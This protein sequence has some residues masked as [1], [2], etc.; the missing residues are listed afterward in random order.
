MTRFKFR[1]KEDPSGKGGQEG[2]LCEWHREIQCDVN[3]GA[4]RKIL[5]ES[6]GTHF[7]K[8]GHLVPVVLWS[9]FLPGLCGFPLGSH[10][11]S[12]HMRL[13][14]LKV[15]VNVYVAMIQ[16]PIH[17][18]VLSTVLIKIVFSCYT[19][20]QSLTPIWQCTSPNQ[21]KGKFNKSEDHTCNSC[22]DWSLYPSLWVINRLQ[23]PLLFLMWLRLL[24]RLEGTNPNPNYISVVDQSN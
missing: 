3:M 18:V 10:S 8:W 16:E 23:T 7:G 11:K 17:C 12:M 22:I 15:W 24:G 19:L 4:A 2:G 20:S 5:D 21:Q 6:A 9:D 13:E 1:L 14:I